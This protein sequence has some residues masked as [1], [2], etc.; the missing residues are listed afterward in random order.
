MFSRLAGMFLVGPSSVWLQEL[1]KKLKH[2]M[3]RHN[4]T[5]DPP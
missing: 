1:E 3:S 4:P 5:G 2:E